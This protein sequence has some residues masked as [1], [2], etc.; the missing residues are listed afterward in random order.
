M[1]K[2]PTL[3]ERILKTR[4]DAEKEAEVAEA[5]EKVAASLPL[6][7]PAEAVVPDKPVV[8]LAS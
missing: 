3:D 2:I 8:E 4:T 7:T 5:E 6:N 1:L